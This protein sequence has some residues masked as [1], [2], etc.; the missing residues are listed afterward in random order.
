LMKG[1]FGSEKWWAAYRSPLLGFVLCTGLGQ[2]QLNLEPVLHRG[3]RDI[4]G[5]YSGDIK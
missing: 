4:V 1:F 5:P 2:S 3:G